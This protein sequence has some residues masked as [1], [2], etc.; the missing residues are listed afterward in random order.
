MEWKR[1]LAVASPRRP[2]QRPRAATAQELLRVCRELQ[3]LFNQVDVPFLI[4]HGGGDVVCDPACVERLYECAASKDKTLKIYPGMWHQL[5]GE[6]D[7]NVEL[8]FGEVVKW[9]M[10]RADQAPAGSVV[11]DGDAADA[12]ATEI[13]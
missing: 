13:K 10:T 6:P 12:D 8:V 3:G 9:L 11:E 2:L 4:V 1:K 7:E 5:V